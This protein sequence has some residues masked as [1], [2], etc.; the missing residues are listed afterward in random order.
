MNLLAA[1][2]RLSFFPEIGRHGREP[3]TRELT[4]VPPYVIVYRIRQDDIV[5]LQIWRDR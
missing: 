1:C 5:I 3:G 4:T 2:N